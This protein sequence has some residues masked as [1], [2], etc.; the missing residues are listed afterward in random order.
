MATFELARIQTAA[1][2]IGVAQ[3]AMEQGMSYATAR[4][5]FGEPIANFPRVS[6]KLA[7]MAVEIMIAR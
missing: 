5:Q 4:V 3:A 6:D 2:A 1:R 7:M